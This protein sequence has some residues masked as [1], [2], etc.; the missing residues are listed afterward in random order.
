MTE[1]TENLIEAFKLSGLFNITRIN[2]IMAQFGTLIGGK[3]ELYYGDRIS[4]V[5]CYKEPISV[6]W[7]LSNQTQVYSSDLGRKYVVR[8]SVNEILEDPDISD[9][10]KTFI[11]FNINMF[12]VS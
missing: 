6:D 11:A 5:L 1:D 10:I 7:A 2:P 4:G 3:Y 8:I 12:L 9:E